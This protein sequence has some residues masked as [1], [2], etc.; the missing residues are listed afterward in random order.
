MT[1]LFLVFWILLFVYVSR[2]LCA[3][4]VLNQGCRT[5]IQ[6]WAAWNGHY[7]WRAAKIS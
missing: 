1:N 2:R 3:E 6:S 4:H 5:Y 7:R